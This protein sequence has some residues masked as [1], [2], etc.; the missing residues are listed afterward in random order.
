M[1][2]CFGSVTFAFFGLWETTLAVAAGAASIPIIIHLLNRRRYLV[3]TWAAMRF[4]LNAQKKVTRRMRLE[5]LILLALRVLLVVLIVAAMA[6]VMPWA[7]TVWANLFPEGAGF[8]TRRATRNHK[9][10]VLDA[11]LSMTA[12]LDGKRTCF[13]RAQELAADVVSQAQ[14]GDG[15]HLLVLNKWCDWV[16]QE[17]SN[18]A[19][20]TIAE[21]RS[22]RASHG[23]ANTAMALKKIADKL[24]DVAR[25]A[26]QYKVHEVYFF[27]DLQQA[28]WLLG[29]GKN[30]EVKKYLN[31]I[32][33]HAETV[34]VDVGK[35][36]SHNLAVTDLTI[37]KPLIV[38]GDNV[39]VVATIKNFG[40]VPRQGLSAKLRIGRGQLKADDPPF[41]M[42][43][44]QE[45]LIDLM[46]GELTTVSFPYQFTK[47]GNYALQVQIGDDDLKADNTRS[48]V[49]TV[50]DTIPVLLLNGKPAPDTSDT[51]TGFLKWA[52]FA[53]W[54][55]P[56]PAFL[57]FRP[58]VID[59]DQFGNLSESSLADYDCIFV[60]DVGTLSAGQ[61]RRLENHLKRGGG[62][63]FSMGKEAAG[64]LGFYNK[65]LF[66]DGKGILPARLTGTVQA[67]EDHY[68]GPSAAAEAWKKP[69]LQAFGTDI[70]RAA[71]LA[72][73]FQRFVEA[74]PAPGVQPTLSLVLKQNPGAKPAP[75]DWN[76]PVESPLLL[77]WNPP[78]PDSKSTDD[79]SRPQQVALYPGKVIL[80]TSTWNIDWNSWPG[81]TSYLPMIQELTRVAV[82]GKVREKA[83]QVGEIL[84]QHLLSGGNRLN[85]TLYL[86]DTH[87][88]PRTVLT[89]GEG[90]LT[91]FEW[92]LTDRSGIYR[93]TVGQDK[94]DY[95]F[96]V[97]PPP[98][99]P[100]SGIS[101]S[102]LT[103]TSADELHRLNPDWQFQIVQDL[104]KIRPSGRQEAV[105]EEVVAG[106][107]GPEL[108]HTLLLA[109]L[110]LLILEVVLAWAFGHFAAIPSAL[111]ER[112]HVHPL[113][114]GLTAVVAGVLFVAIA[115]VLVHAVVTGDFLGFLPETFR[116]WVEGSLNIPAPASGEGTRWDLEF[117]PYLVDSATDPWLAAAMALGVAALLYVAYRQE[118]NHVRPRYKLVLGGLRLFL[119][120]LVLA[121]LL[122]Q[123]KLSFN[124]QGWPHVILLI[125]DSLSMGE[126]DQYQDPQ[127][128]KQVTTLAD[129]LRTNLQKQLPERIKHYEQQ[130]QA[131]LSAAS[132]TS[133]ES[134][135]EEIKSLQQKLKKLETQLAQLESSNWPPT[136]LQ[137]AQALV[138]NVNQ[139]W[140]NYLLHQRQ[141]KVHV[142]H[143][144]AAGKAL[145]LRDAKGNVLKLLDPSDAGMEEAVHQG[146]A[147]LEPYAHDTQ[148]GTAVRQILD[149]FRGSSVAA[150]VVLSDGITTA[151]DNFSEYDRD[152]E[153]VA[154]Y[155]Q[156]KGVP[157]YLVG[158]GDDHDLRDL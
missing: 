144:D 150:V 83:Y 75:P 53:D 30:D 141:M 33:K 56:P 47:A 121:V 93:M 22:V 109:V 138:K 127:L 81:S 50:K 131:K 44:A 77:E 35:K 99:D 140:L 137:L 28:T 27:T 34:F 129:A 145:A 112:T 37:S 62:V 98:H 36:E 89:Q 101:E 3:V 12:Q 95:L 119:V 120:L 40:V 123:L 24:E 65:E 26:Q 116:A 57:P 4:L 55:G 143:L 110:V 11:S 67:P 153:K 147:A 29:G 6:S 74:S 17:L 58:K 128:Q 100:V 152:L 158:V 102:D 69:P 64:S 60:C 25:T 106:R 107:L 156:T 126:T 114:P 82:S 151:A 78:M 134:I 18:N 87:D 133:T 111:T 61:V 52:L 139:D 155:A 157:L 79:K 96:A 105:A 124:R 86:P 117:S 21:I 70:F 130:L 91:V 49:V 103:P 76:G 39:E 71:L 154:E 8:L 80:M 23:N 32:Q 113:W 63:V 115:G 10:I 38:P 92:A 2:A 66:A 148:L 118:G 125:D 20:Q 68:F 94:H 45:K 135:K 1:L 132:G 31:Q 73:R 19:G 85:V 43:D 51:A 48:T 41:E 9:I 7:E 54:P 15:F 72:A 142:Y 136:R 13:E 97:N 146:M 46:P 122:P 104:R 42:L 108:A 16:G 14:S 90:E 59:A 88:G 5:Q 84:Q 149:Q